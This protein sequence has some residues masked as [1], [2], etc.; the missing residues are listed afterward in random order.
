MKSLRKFLKNVKFA[1]LM[2]KAEKL[3]RR[4]EYTQ[5][6]SCLVEVYDISDA[7]MPS[8]SVSLDTNLLCASIAEWSGHYALAIEAVRIVLDQ[9][10][11]TKR[12]LDDEKNYLRYFCKILLEFCESKTNYQTFDSRLIDV[13]F[14]SLR[15]DKVRRILKSSFPITKPAFSEQSAPS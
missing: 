6:L 13:K 5:A 4:S 10:G 15:F 2:L 8:A 11:K 7:T 14:S 3:F 12:Y 1:F 9:T